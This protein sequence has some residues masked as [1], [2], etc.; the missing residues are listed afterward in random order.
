MVD[1]F[2]VKYIGA[3]HANNL[4]SVLTEHNIIS[5]DWKEEKIFGLTIN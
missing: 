5:K 3:E 1:D 4:I 2:A